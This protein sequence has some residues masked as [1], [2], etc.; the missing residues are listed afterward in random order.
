[1]TAVA[2]QAAEGG[3]LQMLGLVE[4][5][6]AGELD[7]KTGRFRAAKVTILFDLA[8]CTKFRYRIANPKMGGYFSR[9]LNAT[10]AAAEDDGVC[11]LTGQR[12]PLQAGPMPKPLLP[13]LGPTVLMSMNPDTPCQRRYRRIGND[14]FP[15]GR[16]T[17]S[18]LNAALVQLTK[19]DRKGKNWMPVP[20]ITKKK[21]NLLLVYLESSPLLAH[22]I[23]ELFSGADQSD[24]LYSK[25]CEEVCKALQAR[26]ASDSDLLHVLVLNKIDPGRVQV[27]LNE[28]FTAEQVIRGSEEWRQGARNRPVLTLQNED[29]VP[30]PTDVMRCLQMKWE[31][32]G[33]THADAPGCRLT[34]VFDVLVTGRSGSGESAALLLGMT[35]RRSSALLAAIGHATH[36]GGKEA[37][38]NFSRDVGRNPVIA[39]SLLGITLNKLGYKKETYMQD[40]AFLVGRFL[41]LADTL[42][43]EYS[44]EVRKDLPPQLLGNALIP[45][46][47]GDPSKGIARMGRLRVYQAWAKKSGTAL[48]RW[49]CGEM[50]K[51]AAE[52]AAKLPKRRLN[53]AEQAQLLLG[54]LA[55]AEK[56]ETAIAEGVNQ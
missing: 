27:E 16:E 29:Y 54:Y 24:E 8:D 47:I 17:V 6:L 52:V 9:R 14:V 53:D 48:A 39:A 11:A 56:E 12:A 19:P 55:R 18:D 42:H 51:I 34:E 1:L 3:S 36:R 26:A 20:G 43:A 45:T 22:R 40:P 15:A 10:E 7:Q 41:S 37:W 25:L 2:L 44:K 13:V 23:A 31:R 49:S 32:G 35:L 4:T 30:S 50:G 38:K 46:A 28:A 21:S 33:A 5:L